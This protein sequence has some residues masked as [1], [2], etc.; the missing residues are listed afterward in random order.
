LGAILYKLLSGGPP[1]LAETLAETWE[2]MRTQMP[3]SPSAMQAG[4]PAVLDAICLRCLAKKAQDRYASAA[5]LAEELHRF[6]TPQRA[7]SPSFPGPALPNR[8]APAANPLANPAV[9]TSGDNLLHR[10]WDDL[11]SDL[12][13][14]L[15]LAFNQARREKKD[16]ISTRTLFAALIRLQPGRLPELLHLL[17]QGALPE[18]IGEDILTESQILQHTPKLSSCVE[19][20]LLHLGAAKPRGHKLVAEEVFVDIAKFGTGTSVVR[21]RTHGVT[22]ELIDSFLG[23]LGWKVVRRQQDDPSVE[24]DRAGPVHEPPP[25]AAA[26]TGVWARIAGWFSGRSR[27]KP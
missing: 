25:V 22:P 23:Q 9:E 2:Q 7:A 26:P 21:L 27:K 24:A 8:T 12:Q 1:F 10:L 15:A 19:H 13:D 14:A 6:L 17:P 4:V 3:P 20:A 11:D 16:R 18:P 5:E